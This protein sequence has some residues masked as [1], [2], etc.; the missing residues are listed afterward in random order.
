MA[1]FL[2]FTKDTLGAHAER[3]DAEAHNAENG[4]DVII[5]TL[6]E[7]LACTAITP[8]H[9]LKLYNLAVKSVDPDAKEEKSIGKD[10]KTAGTKLFAALDAAFGSDDAQA[11]AE[12]DAAVKQEKAPRK[13]KEPSERSGP[14][15]EYAGRYW[16]VAPV[17]P[18][19]RRAP[20]ERG[21]PARGYNSMNV[22]RNNPGISTEDYLAKGGR[23]RDLQKDFKVNKNILEVVGDEAARAKFVEET[24]AQRK[25]EDE[26][27]RVAAEKAAADA[28]AAAEKKAADEAAKKEAAA[29]AE[30]ADADKKAA[31]AKAAETK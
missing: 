21:N 24:L 28:K 18:K 13:K 5:T 29:A 2:T 15:G 16:V 12:L 25:I 11:S 6:D 3:A 22:I 8:A 27:A 23:L 4:G 30:K 7:L 20:T 9:M 14:M 31:E 26:K 10:A 19:P 17:E 1:K